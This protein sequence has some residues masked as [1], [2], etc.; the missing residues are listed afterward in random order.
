MGFVC[1]FK[2]SYQAFIISEE[3][4]AMSSDNRFI[5]DTIKVNVIPEKKGTFLKHTEYEVH[6]LIYRVSTSNL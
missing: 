6:N 1:F 4:G 2:N 3:F 5:S